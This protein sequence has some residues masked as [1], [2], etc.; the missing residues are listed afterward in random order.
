MSSRDPGLASSLRRLGIELGERLNGAACVLEY[1]HGPGLA[2]AWVRR[3]RIKDVETRAGV[4]A[5]DDAPRGAVPLFDQGLHYAAG[6]TVLSHPPD[7]I[8]GDGSCCLQG[9]EPRAEVRAG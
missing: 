4:G 6:S 5:G 3:S 1:S 2:G 7:L 8:R 9:V